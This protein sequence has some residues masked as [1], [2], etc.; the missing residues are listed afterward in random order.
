MLELPIYN[1]EGKETDKIQL[2]AEIFAVKE[3][4][5]LLAQAVR[6]YLANQR[7][8][9]AS[10]KTRGEVQGSSR[11]I[12]RQKGTGRARH[13]SIRA[14]VFRGGGIVFGP[15][16]KDFSLKFPPKMKKSALFLSLTQKFQ[17][18]S[19]YVISPINEVE[20]KTKKIV[21]TLENMQFTPEEEKI[22][23]VVNDLSSN[24]KLAT[25]NL[26]ST[27]VKKYTLLNALDILNNKKIVFDKEALLKLIEPFEKKEKPKLEKPKKTKSVKK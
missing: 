3:N 19:I 9:N 13:G 8:G 14:N 17:A 4:P 23:I 6:I 11:K 25:R 16:P 21:K 5:A 26:K 15:R 27:T 2:P 20:N 1:L 12:Y 18:K 10:T 22:I 24:L 7:Q